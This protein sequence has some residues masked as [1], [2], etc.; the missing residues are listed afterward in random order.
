MK[1][2]Y[3]I[4]SFLMLMIYSTAS[5]SSDMNFY[6]GIFNT[7]KDKIHPRILNQ[8]PSS[9]RNKLKDIKLILV[10]DARTVTLAATGKEDKNIYISLG[11]IDGLFNYVDCVLIEAAYPKS[12]A[13][14]DIY[15]EYYFDRVVSN[16]NRPPL[17]VARLNFGD[18]EKK[19][20][21]W[22]NNDA[23]DSAR[24]GMIFSALINVLVHEYGHHIVGFSKRSDTISAMRDIEKRVDNW[25]Y[26][27]LDK[28]GEKPASGAVFAL[29][30]LAQMERYR[31]NLRNKNKDNSS[32]RQITRTHPKPSERVSVAYDYTCNRD[33]TSKVEEKGCLLLDGLIK[34]Y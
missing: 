20:D 10:E 29:G 28:I 15:F 32:F 4:L 8:L 22:F 34:S 33:N 19:L 11:F 3:Y 17:I 23:L 21:Y 25:A 31:R 9:D 14:C 24:K 16:S 13:V 2:N 1:K 5:F 12:K 30:Y 6:K 18:N 26:S 7:Y 27:F